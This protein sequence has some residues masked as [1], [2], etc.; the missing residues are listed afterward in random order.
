[1]VD[2][3]SNDKAL[4]F[5]DH[6]LKEGNSII[7]TDRHHVKV[8]NEKYPIFEVS[9][10]NYMQPVMKKYK[11]LKKTGSAT[12]EDVK[13]QQEIHDEINQMLELVK[14][15]YDYYLASLYAGGIQ[16]EMKFADVLRSKD[17]NDFKTEEMEPLWKIA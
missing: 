10:E 5:I 12:R 3:A 11:E 15:K 1:M 4:S 13:K 6:H 14:K 7:G 16:D 17:I 9:Y 2:I 8:R